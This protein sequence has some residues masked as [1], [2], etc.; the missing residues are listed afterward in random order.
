MII[1]FNHA[2]ICITRQ[3]LLICYK[4]ILAQLKQICK[5][6]HERISKLEYLKYDLE[7][8]V[9]Q[10]DFVVSYRFFDEIERHIIPVIL[11]II[12]ILIII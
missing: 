8:E 1:Y 12:F 9:R 7:Y 3:E 2:V 11:V 6:Y 4:T 10:K 5:E